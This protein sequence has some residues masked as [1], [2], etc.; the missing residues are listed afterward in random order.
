[1][2]KLPQPFVGEAAA[3]VTLANRTTSLHRNVTHPGIHHRIP[4]PPSPTPRSTTF[5]NAPPLSFPF[6]AQSP[7][8]FLRCKARIPAYFRDVLLLL[9][10]LKINST[11]PCRDSLPAI[12]HLKLRQADIPSFAQMPPGKGSMG[13][14]S[15]AIPEMVIKWPKT[16]LKNSYFNPERTKGQKKTWRWLD[17]DQLTSRP[18]Q[19]TYPPALRPDHRQ[20]PAAAKD[21]PKCKRL[22]EGKREGRR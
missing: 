14:R 17:E 8:Y 19:A 4:P 20:S 15:K 13:T 7:R 9:L 16:I 11:S 10:F 12:H 22:E 6:L 21:R 18:F 5:T 3:F 1:M 2:C